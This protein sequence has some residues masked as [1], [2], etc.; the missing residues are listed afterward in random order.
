VT[1]HARTAI[2]QMLRIPRP[3]RYRPLWITL[4]IAAVL[5]GVSGSLTRATPAA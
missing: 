5:G 3:R 1:G 4:A 2:A